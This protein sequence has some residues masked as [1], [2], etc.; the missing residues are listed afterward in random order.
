[1]S[2]RDGPDD[3]AGADEGRRSFGMRMTRARLI[4]W[5]VYLALLLLLWLTV[6]N[7]FKLV[8]VGPSAEA[9]APALNPSSSYLVDRRQPEELQRDIIVL[10]AHRPG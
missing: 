5:G 10:W 6:L 4:R 9:M 1:M 7:R 2:D 8:E 3:E